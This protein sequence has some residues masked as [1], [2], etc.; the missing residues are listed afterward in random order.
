MFKR[1]QT[2][3]LLAVFLLIVPPFFYLFNYSQPR[4]LNVD[5]KTDYELPFPGLLPDHPLYLVKM[6]RDQTLVFITRDF[7]SRARMQLELSDKRIRAGELLIDEKKYDLAIS[8]FSKGERYFEQAIETL[9]S[10]KQQGQ[11][12]TTDIIDQM[13]RSNKKHIIV[14]SQRAKNINKSL[15]GEM[16]LVLE[17]NKKNSQT[18]QTLQ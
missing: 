1:L 6:L 3:I 15:L 8:T 14:L 13:K 12:P 10:A 2:P 5:N 11:A 9:K 4:S 7:E 16:V 17:L 18:L